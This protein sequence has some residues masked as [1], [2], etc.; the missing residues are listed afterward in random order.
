MATV[1]ADSTV[2]CPAR[3]S[4]QRRSSFQPMSIKRPSPAWTGP[5]A[6]HTVLPAAALPIPAQSRRGIIQPLHQPAVLLRR[7][8]PYLVFRSRPLVCTLFQPL[9]QQDKSIPLPIEALDAVPLSAAQAT[10]RALQRLPV[11]AVLKL[12][13]Q[14]L[15]LPMKGFPFPGGSTSLP[16]YCVPHTIPLRSCRC[17][18]SL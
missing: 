4:A 12:R 6:V 3:T 10:A 13:A 14:V 7:Q 11:A 8:L 15:W 9:I 18:G 5:D 17:C 2:P 1:P 16:K